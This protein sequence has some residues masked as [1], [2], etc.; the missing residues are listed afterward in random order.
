MVNDET[1]YRLLKLIEAN[2]EMSQR[3]LAKA[4]GV[5]LGK[6]NY[7]LRAVV[8]RGLVKVRNFKANPNKQAYAYYLT[9]RG[10]E[11][12]ARVTSRFLQRKMIEYEELKRDIAQLKREAAMTQAT[13]GD[14]V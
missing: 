11:E 8:E 7:C 3:D 1:H 4:M 5:S 14:V 13:E 10:I 12:K 6:A 9:P 2:P